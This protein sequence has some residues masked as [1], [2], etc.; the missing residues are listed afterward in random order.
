MARGTGRSK[1]PPSGRWHQKQL[2][3]RSPR[4]WLPASF[5]PVLPGVRSQLERVHQILRD[6]RYRIA[7]DAPNPVNPCGDGRSWVVLC[8]PT[9]KLPKDVD[10]ADFA[11]QRLQSEGVRAE[12]VGYVDD[13]HQT[14]YV[15][16]SPPPEPSRE[17]TPKQAPAPQIDIRNELLQKIYGVNVSKLSRITSAAVKKEWMDA[18]RGEEPSG[19]YIVQETMQQTR[20]AIGVT[21]PE[22]LPA[23]ERADAQPFAAPGGRPNLVLGEWFDRMLQQARL[24]TSLIFGGNPPGDARRLS[25]DFFREVFDA[26]RPD[27]Q[28]EFVIAAR[29]ERMNNRE[30]LAYIASVKHRS[31]SYAGKLRTKYRRAS[32]KARMTSSAARLS[33]IDR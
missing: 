21:P 12:D 27:K 17:P 18:H 2:K 26:L 11:R 3:K 30:L 23:S 10:P 9:S 5:G 29:E 14:I 15:A 25:P 8:K 1:K 4:S 24:V 16:V 7:T 20:D 22:Q 31:G 32:G 33:T 13:N 19:E 6:S 28:K